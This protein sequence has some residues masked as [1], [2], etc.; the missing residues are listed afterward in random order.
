VIT[1][2]VAYK[3][4]TIDND[5][6][7]VVASLMESIKDD[8]LRLKR[9][10]PQYVALKKLINS[11]GVNNASILT[12]L[13]SLISYQLSIPGEEYW[14]RFADF[15]SK[16]NVQLNTD[17]FKKFLLNVKCT[18]LLDQK[19]RRISRVLSSDLPGKLLS[20]GLRYCNNIEAFMREL[21]RIL[22]V[23]E[24]SKT[25]VFSAKMYSYL[26]DVSGQVVDLGKTPIPVDYRNSLLALTSCIIT[27]C[28]GLPLKECAL[29][30]TSSTYSKYVRNAWMSVCNQLGIS[31]LELDAF[32]WIFTGV[33]IS[34]DFNV[35]K[36]VKLL[37]EKYS[38]NIREDVVRILLECVE[39][40]V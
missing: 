3:V 35:S 29:K 19:L 27:D 21:S 5:R 31:C 23:S 17:Y 9:S 36:I 34:S 33:A 16:P 20:N 13:N 24:D 39:K 18:R 2:R 10:D 4:V 22:K 1:V 26:C 37:K 32:T 14:G 15:F 7:H 28:G 38:V 30:L 6:V 8:V 25:I 11:V 40:Y 12:V